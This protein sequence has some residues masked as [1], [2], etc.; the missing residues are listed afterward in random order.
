MTTFRNSQHKSL[1]K[2]PQMQHH[3]FGSIGILGQGKAGGVY[4][5]IE[6]NMEGR[7]SRGECHP[8]SLH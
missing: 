3:S 1:C 6:V 7:Q 8:L 4:R 5:K 2:V